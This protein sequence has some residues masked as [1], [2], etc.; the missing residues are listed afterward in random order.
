M[1]PFHYRADRRGRQ[2]GKPGLVPILCIDGVINAI[3]AKS[4]L[5]SLTGSVCHQAH[6]SSRQADALLVGFDPAAWRSHGHRRIAS[7]VDAATLAG[8][9]FHPAVNRPI[10]IRVTSQLPD[11]LTR[12]NPEQRAAVETVDGPLLVLAGAGTGKTRVLTT[13]FAHI[14]L[15]KRAFPNQIL[16][17]T[18]TNKAAREMRERIAAILGAPAEGLWLGTFHAL[19]ARMLRRHAEHVG[20]SSNFS[21]LDT[22]D[23]LRVLKQTMEAERIDAKRWV[24][25]GLMGVIQRWKDRGLTPA[26]ITPNGD[27]DFA[28][29]KA[30]ALYA[31][32]QARLRT[33]HAA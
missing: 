30:R 29:G 21:I 28:N 25:A 31:A 3:I 17:V 33:L 27:S 19:C 6:A 22:D 32:Y 9:H 8:P 11:Y 18:F 24:P 26:R 20:L 14:L 12:L 23:Q 16:A 10:S 1:G 4:F 13:R 15:T 5:R 7:G 2:V